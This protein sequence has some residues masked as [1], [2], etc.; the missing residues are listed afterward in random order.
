MALVPIKGEYSTR[1]Q[2]LDVPARVR[3]R[4]GERAVDAVGRAMERLNR[5]K[6]VTIS[7][8]GTALD[9]GEPW[10]DHWKITFGVRAWGG[11]DIVAE[12]IVWLPASATPREQGSPLVSKEFTYSRKP[13]KP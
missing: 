3:P 4:D 1:G 10:V 12:Y 11:W 5:V 6:V 9:D 2:T 8:A 7:Y 13:T